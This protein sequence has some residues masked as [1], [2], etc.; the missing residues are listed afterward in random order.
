MT[1][2]GQKIESKR[3]LSL[4]RVWKTRHFLHPVLF[5]YSI[6]FISFFERHFHTLTFVTLSLHPHVCGKY[7]YAVKQGIFR[8]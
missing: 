7:I 6:S 3:Q 8:G 1:V 4:S 5:F 2:G